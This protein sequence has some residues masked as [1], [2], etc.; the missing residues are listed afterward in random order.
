MHHIHYRF[1]FVYVMQV[2]LSAFRCD[3]NCTD[4]VIVI[5]TSV[6][7][8]TDGANGGCRLIFGLNIFY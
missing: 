3:L 5:V 1:K 2:L 8:L 4:V 7:R 6:F